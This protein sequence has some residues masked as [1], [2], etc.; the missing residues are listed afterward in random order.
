M[1]KLNK[2]KTC[3]CVIPQPNCFSGT[4]IRCNK[5]F[6]SQKSS[7]DS[8]PIHE[9]IAISS[10]EILDN[11]CSAYEFIDFDKLGTPEDD[12]AKTDNEKLLYQIAYNRGVLDGVKRESER[13]FSEQ[14]INEMFDTLK[15]NSVNNIATITNVDLFISSWKQEL[16]KKQE[17]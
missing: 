9:V 14:V 2:S 12:L 8:K 3:D 17:N 5:P 1:E 7:D 10:Q 11:R 6:V 15:R 13:R 16:K 4:C